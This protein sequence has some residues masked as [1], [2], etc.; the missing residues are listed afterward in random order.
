MGKLPTPAEYLEVYKAKI[1]PNQ[2]K[3]YKYL[4]FDEMPEY[5]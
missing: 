5:K 2:A 1:E 4:Q 3:I